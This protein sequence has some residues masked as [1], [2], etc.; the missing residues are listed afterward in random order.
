MVVPRRLQ[1][2]F[3]LN[4]VS[5]ALLA[6]TTTF[7]STFTILDRRPVNS[8]DAVNEGRY[9]CPYYP[10]IKSNDP[11]G[12]IIY[13]T[14]G[15]TEYGGVC[16]APNGNFLMVPHGFFQGR[17][18]MYIMAPWGLRVTK[19]K[20]PVHTKWYKSCEK[21]GIYY[22]DCVFTK[23][24]IYITMRSNG[25]SPCKPDKILKFTADGKFVKIMA[26]GAAFLRLTTGGGYLYST[27]RNSKDVLVYDMA[28]D[29]QIRRFQ[30][31]SGNGRGLAFDM[32][33]NLH[34]ATFGKTVEVFTYKGKKLRQT[35]YKELTQADGIVV[36]NENNIL[37]ADRAGKVFVFNRANKLIKKIDPPGSYPMYDVDIGYKCTLLVVNPTGTYLY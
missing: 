20:L 26:T 10:A 16:V 34:V 2:L 33:G 3:L 32:S 8:T 29:R 7:A 30:L 27:V 31:T 6:E 37:I 9:S 12:L 19:L 22:G 13:P 21:V 4:F 28:T 15:S 1:F 17:K 36:D 24:A 18:Y 11:Y 25:D 35:T 23:N 5:T 14:A